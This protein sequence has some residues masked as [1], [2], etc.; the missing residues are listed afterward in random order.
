MSIHHVLFFCFV[1]ALCGGDSVSAKLNIYAGA[2]GGNGS[3][4]CYLSSSGRTKFFCKDECEAK[5]IL[6]KTD[7][8]RAQS[9]RYSTT[10]RNNSSGEEILS[11]TITHLIKSDSGR[12][13]SGLGKNLVPDS[14]CDFEV[15]VLDASLLEDHSDFIQADI[16]GENITFGCPST[17]QQKQKFL[18][19]GDC[20]KEE[21]IIIETEENR[22]QNGRHSIEYIEGSALGLHVTITEV[23]TSDTGWYRC[24]YGRALSP[25]SYYDRDILVLTATT[26]SKPNW[27]HRPFTTPVPSASTLTSTQSDQQLTETTPSPAATTS[28]PNWTHRP[29]TTPVPSASTP[30]TP[31]Q[32]LSS[33]S[34]SFTPS[35]AFPETTEFTVPVYHPGYFLP[36]VVCVSLV[37]VLIAVLLL[38]YIRK[39]RRH[40]TLNSRN[41]EVIFSLLYTTQ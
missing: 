26:T 8:V 13:R 11:V 21:D 37:G 32:S 10:Y 39:T 25:D 17:V 1:S 30:T 40:V 19:K 14:Y 23:T 6:I 9:G 38:L 41:M 33:S 3:L 35:S 7:E 34:G 24:G 5:D 36:L 27:T 12:Y 20:I 15:R 18:C 28:K 4:D 16:E 31:T 29:F 22:A 2:A